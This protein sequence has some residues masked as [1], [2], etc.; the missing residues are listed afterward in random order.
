MKEPVDVVYSGGG[1]LV[2]T[3][4]GAHARL[5]EQYDVVATT[6]TSAGSM[7][8]AA[9]GVGFTP[10]QIRALLLKTF[11]SGK[12]LLDGSLF[13]TF[14]GFGYYKGDRIHSILRQAF[15]GRMSQLKHDTR[16]VVCDLWTRQPVLVT[17][18]SHPGALVADV[19]RCSMSI[20]VFFQAARLEQDNARLYVDGGCAVNFA[21]DAMDDR[22]ERTIG[23]RFH[24]NHEVLP[25]RGGDWKAYANAMASLFMYASNNA[26][27]SSKTTASVIRIETKEDSLK[28]DLTAADVSRRYSEGWNSVQSWLETPRG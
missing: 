9:H 8:A 7:V 28:F 1:T 26:H 2:C 16:I 20:P 22:P 18:E 19:V 5:C 21:L 3:E 27:E 6:G 23:V 4:A 12:S 14:N 17:R 25:V 11:G 15:P 24:E 13:G 10:T